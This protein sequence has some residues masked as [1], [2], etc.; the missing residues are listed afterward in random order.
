MDDEAVDVF[1]TPDIDHDGY[2]DLAIGQSGGGTQ[3]RM[4]LFLYRPNEDATRRSAIPLRA[5]PATASSTRSSTPASPP[6]Q[7]V[8][9]TAPTARERKLRRAPRRHGRSRVLDHADL[10]P[11]GKREGRGPVRV[12]GDGT[13]ARIL[14]D[15]EG[16]PFDGGDNV[17][18][19][20]AS[21]SM[22]RPTSRAA[23]RRSCA[24]ASGMTWW[25]CGRR[26]G[27]KCACRA[28]RRRGAR[29]LRYVDLV[30]DRHGLAPSAQGRRSG[31]GPAGPLN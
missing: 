11:A 10:V 12:H 2:A 22:T 27:C 4:R 1:E 23:H 18:P 14:L 28:E 13:V 3:A 16:S 30:I 9:D 8:A 5:S 24:P 31:V 6:S 25:R 29:W 7:R 26:A 20:T 15:G 19:S 17:A 21:I